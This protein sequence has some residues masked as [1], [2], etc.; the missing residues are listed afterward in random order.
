MELLRV[1]SSTLGDLVA[2]ESVFGWIVTG[3]LPGLHSKEFSTYTSRYARKEVNGKSKRIVKPNYR[4]HEL[5]RNGPEPH[6]DKRGKS[7]H[8]MAY[9]HYL[10]KKLKLKLATLQR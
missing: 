6:S 9:R 7:F 1:Q 4:G 8:R 5:L 2:R 10:A 3:P